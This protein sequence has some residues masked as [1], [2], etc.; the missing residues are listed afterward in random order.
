M[1]NASNLKLH[2]QLPQAVAIFRPTQET[3]LLMVMRKLLSLFQL[4]TIRGLVKAVPAPCC[5]TTKVDDHE[6]LQS[7]QSEVAFKIICNM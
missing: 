2:L 1:V 5:T 3:L 7:R 6:A 4:L